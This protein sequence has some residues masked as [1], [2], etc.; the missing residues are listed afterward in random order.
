MKQLK[1]LTRKLKILL[2]KKHGPHWRRQ[3]QVKELAKELEKIKL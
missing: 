2:H 1:K 3:L